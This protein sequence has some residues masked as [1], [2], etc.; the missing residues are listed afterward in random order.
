MANA[1]VGLR[2][3]LT[4]LG[5][6]T[7]LGAAG[8]MTATGASAAETPRAVA[9]APVWKPL[10][11]PGVG[12]RIDAVSISP[13]SAGQEIATGD[14]LGV[15]TTAD[16]GQTWSGG[17]GLPSQEMAAVSW[18]SQRPG[19]VWA[20]SMSGPV[21][22]TD[23]GATWT[24]RRAGMPAVSASTYTAAVEKVLIDPASDQHLVAVGGSRRDWSSPRN[25]DFGVVWESTD[26]GGRWSAVA[27]LPGSPNIVDATW[28]GIPGQLVAVAA[29]QGLEISADFG[30]SWRQ[31]GG[32]SALDPRS[33]AVD[34]TDPL[35]WWVGT[36]HGLLGPS[37]AGSIVR[38]EDGGVTWVASNA[39][40]MAH[41]DQSD[42]YRSEY[43]QIVVSPTSP[44]VLYAAQHGFWGGNIY[45]STDGGRSWK[46]LVTGSNHG[47]LP[48]GSGPAASA[49]AV[50]PRDARHVLAGGWESL[51]ESH[52]GGGSW[53]DATTS[54]ATGGY[55]GR[56]FSG[57]VAQGIAFAPAGSP[58]LALV[59]MDGANPLVSRDSGS[60]WSAP[61][62]AY[63]SWDGGYAVSWAST[64]TLYALLGQAGAFNGIARS[65]DG[66]KGFAV[67][68][69]AGAGLPAQYSWTAD[70]PQGIV[71]TRAGT[72]LA[73]IGGALYRSVDGGAHWAVVAAGRHY[74][75]LALS[76]DGGTVWVSST[77]G[78]F[79]TTDGSRLTAVGGPAF[80][81]QD[82]TLTADP[83]S[84]GVL[85]AV[86]W[87]TAGGGLWRYVGGSWT[88]LSTNTQVAA[89]AVDPTDT[90]RLLAVIGDRPYHDVSAGGV[91]LSTDGG[92]SWNDV[93]GT[94]PMP[95]AS[96][97]AW[98]PRHP[99]H[100]VVGTYG[101]GFW[102][103]D[104][105]PAVSSAAANL[106]GGASRLGTHPSRLT[107]RFDWGAGLRARFAAQQP[108]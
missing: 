95:R 69:G 15:A 94:L 85:Y 33:V 5:A 46:A 13:W 44:S 59:G 74:G 79:A 63:D 30:H 108:H 11:E 29:G 45:G 101:G 12:G 43:T 92:T 32:V 70:S 77:A 88:Q 20:G 27:S 64:S 48:F 83:T 28:T 104:F 62:H 81:P 38:T 3:R 82:G 56:G 19:V 21:Q 16:D 80:G 42:D 54:T 55:V 76:A 49:I 105:G 97:A 106:S 47:E 61:V 68:V 36:G 40:L 34:P 10:G 107:H 23:G 73:T 98:D 7:A 53:V 71:A 93:T 67:A 24:A 8:L 58:S 41:D 89:V 87:R 66:G 2:N 1:R 90:S 9:T 50:D 103:A 18:D 14:M 22:S 65:T 100:A 51:L 75:A 52:D 17:T 6:V 60:T 31:A 25:P 35:R 78:T 39:G 72:V 102:Q 99:G 86:G 84:P 37:A 57:L 91:L 4:V 96:A 26:G